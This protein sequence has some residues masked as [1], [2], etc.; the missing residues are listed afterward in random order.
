M[1]PF[2]TTIG[3]TTVTLLT[4]LLINF[5]FSKLKYNSSRVLLYIRRIRSLKQLHMQQ[6]K[7]NDKKT[8]EKGNIDKNGTTQAESQQCVASKKKDF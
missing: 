6:T 7:Y 4:R 1:L 3:L 5:Q 2:R 8:K